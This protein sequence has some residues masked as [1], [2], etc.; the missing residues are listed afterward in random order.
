M[1]LRKNRL[2]AP[3]PALSAGVLYVNTNAIMAAVKAQKKHGE[4]HGERRTK[5]SGGDPRF[6]IADFAEP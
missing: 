1:I 3:S 2:L 4:S 6:L 5:I